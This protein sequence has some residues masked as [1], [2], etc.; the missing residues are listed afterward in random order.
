MSIIITNLGGKN[1][2]H[3]KV[4]CFSKGR[5]TSFRNHV[6]LGTT[7]LGTTLVQKQQNSAVS[8]PTVGFENPEYEVLPVEIKDSQGYADFKRV[9]V[10]L[11]QRS[12]VFAKMLTKSGS[13]KNQFY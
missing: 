8:S 2:S 11:N 7:S 6:T 4:Y 13:L 3:I 5:T 10:R 9:M 1:P 12:T